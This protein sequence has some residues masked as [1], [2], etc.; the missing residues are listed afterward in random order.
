LT[1]GARLWH[2]LQDV[3]RLYLFALVLQ[4]FILI[5]YIVKAPQ[6]HQTAKDVILYLLDTVT[7]AAP[8]GLPTVLLLVGI[9]AGGRLK[10]DG[11]L[12]MFPEILKRGA[13]VDVV[14]FDKT[15]TLTQS[16]VSDAY[17]GTSQR[18]SGVAC[19]PLQQASLLCYMSAV[20]FGYVLYAQSD[21]HLSMFNSVLLLQRNAA[22]SNTI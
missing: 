9:I 2:L 4:F 3:I 5:P 22:V 16:T 20:V 6:R 14:C 19:Q 17:P 1:N 12:L 11:L 8:P 18:T 10:R 15:G 7:Y 21:M 13:A